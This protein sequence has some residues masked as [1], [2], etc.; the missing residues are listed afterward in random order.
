M[1]SIEFEYQQT[2]TIVQANLNDRFETALNKYK[3]KTNVDINNLCYLA[4]GRNINKND[5]IE[6]IMNTN[7]KQNK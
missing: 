4:N 6:D 3:I 5:I 2:K 1:V 7:D